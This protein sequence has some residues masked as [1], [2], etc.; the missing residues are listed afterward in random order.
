MLVV[1]T[2]ATSLAAVSERGEHFGNAGCDE[3]PTAL[4]VEVLTP[5]DAWRLA[6]DPLAQA[7]PDLTGLVVEE[8]STAAASAGVDHASRCRPLTGYSRQTRW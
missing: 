8:H 4:D 5:G 6:V 7:H 3:L 1:A 2:A